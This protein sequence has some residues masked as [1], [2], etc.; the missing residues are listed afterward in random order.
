MT[1][2]HCRRPLVIPSE[3]RNLLFPASEMSAQ[4]KD[5]LERPSPDN[6][7]KLLA[8]AAL[9][10]FHGLVQLIVDRVLGFCFLVRSLRVSI[11][12]IGAD[13]IVD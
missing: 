4:K 1:V 10:N 9:Q 11:F 8:V 13:G 2:R 5:G 6:P 3:A 7:K 12:V